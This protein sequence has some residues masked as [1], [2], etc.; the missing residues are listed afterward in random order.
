MRQ[1]SRWL[2]FLIHILIT[3]YIPYYYYNYSGVRTTLWFL[4]TVFS[5]IWIMFN[6]INIIIVRDKDIDLRANFISYLR[7]K[8]PK[9]VFH[10][11][12]IY[13]IKY[14]PV[15]NNYHI[16]KFGLI[17]LRSISTFDADYIDSELHLSS[18]CKEL[19]DGK[20]HKIIKEKNLIKSKSDVLN[21]WDG[22]TSDKVR[23]DF[24]IK[25]II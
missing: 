17:R 21:K 3:L 13:Y 8:L 6:I 7:P 24:K 16:Y 12:G 9:K 4:F 1:F 20:F 14:D 15:K 10:E 22:Y 11:S 5:V 2:L 25:E 23:R 19:L 18:K